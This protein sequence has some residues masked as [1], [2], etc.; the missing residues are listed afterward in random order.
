MGVF[1]APTDSQNILAGDLE[2]FNPNMSIR[3]ALPHCFE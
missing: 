1:L 3:I 2:F